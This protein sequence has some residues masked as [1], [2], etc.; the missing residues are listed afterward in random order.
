MFGAADEELSA[1]Y[2]A[3]KRTGKKDLIAEVAYRYGRRY[4]L[5][6]NE[7]AAARQYLQP[8]R[9]G[10]SVE[11]RLNALQLESCILSREGRAREQALMLTEMLH[12]ID[13]QQPEHAEARI[14]GTQTL[15]ALAREIYIP[16]AVPIVEGQLGGEER[17]PPRKLHG[18]ESRHR[19]RQGRPSQTKGRTR[20]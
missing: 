13:P 19:R 15:A 8:I 2:E 5:S 1:A 4:A 3:A 20:A 6:S 18:R 12:M 10:G 7:P 14:R 9:D 11:S 16:E 17:N